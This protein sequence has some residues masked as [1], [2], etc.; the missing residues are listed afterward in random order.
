MAVAQQPNTDVCLAGYWGIGTPQQGVPDKVLQA[1]REEPWRGLFEPCVEHPLTEVEVEGTVPKALQGTMFRNGRL[2]PPPPPRPLPSIFKVVFKDGRV[3]AQNRFV[4]TDSWDPDAPEG[5]GS[6]G[7]VRGWTRRPGGWLKN[8]FKLPAKT[9]NTSVMLKGGKLYALGEGSKPSEIDPVTLETLAES[10]LGGIQAFYSAHPST[11]VLT[12]ETF[13]IGIGGEK[14]AIEVSRLYPNGTLDKSSSFVPPA[15][16]FWHDNT[17]TDEYVVAVTPP[18]VATLKRIIFAFLGFGPVGKAFTWDDSRKSEAFFFSKETLELVNKI[19]LPG[20]PSLYHIVNGF[21]EEKGG[22]VTVTLVKLREGGGRAKLE[23][24]FEDIM[25]SRFSDDTLCDQYKYEIDV[26]AGKVLS[27]GLAAPV[28]GSLPMELPGIDPRFLGK[29]N[30]FVYT[31]S[32]L[33][34]AGFLNCV[35]S[36]DLQATGAAAWKT[37]DFG[38]L[39]YGGE[40]IFVPRSDDAEEGDGFLIV[41]VYNAKKHTTDVEVL[42]AQEVDAPPLF[43]AHIP[44]HMGTSFHGIFT[45]ETYL[46]TDVET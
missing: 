46:P 39:R 23:A 30:R 42:D 14:G 8:V 32:M 11:D 35:Q 41:L 20:K 3:Y 4:A 45:P 19:E 13:N 9:L 28:E 26:T 40:P 38:H 2:S 31:N 33:G 44:W 17:I 5:K 24:V 16:A 25:G 27:H 21:Q 6:A 15:S 7:A 43:V 22:P 18:Y 37:H 10:D 34:D 1:I 36:C 12:G 29:R